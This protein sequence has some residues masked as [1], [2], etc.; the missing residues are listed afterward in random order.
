MY[1]IRRIE[2]RAELSS[3]ESVFADVLCR[4]FHNDPYYRYIMPN[5]RKNM[6]QMHWWWR[7]LLRYTLKFGDIYYTD[8]HKAIAMWLGPEKP[9]VNDAKILSMGLI[10]YPFKVGIRNFMRLLDISEQWGK[11]HKLM[12]KRHYYLMVIVKPSI[13]MVQKAQNTILTN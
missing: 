12:A 5:S 13:Y 11:G 4:A 7:I 10:R 6:A 2:T 9:M 1:K 8:D 3:F